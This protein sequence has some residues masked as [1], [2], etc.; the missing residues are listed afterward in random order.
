MD[1]ISLHQRN[2]KC[3]LSPM[4]TTLSVNQL[5]K[6]WNYSDIPFICF[7]GDEAGRTASK[8]IAKKF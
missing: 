2:I 6:L 1:V 3:C 8:N 4:G 7:D 5:T